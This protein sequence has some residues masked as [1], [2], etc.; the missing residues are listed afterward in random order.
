MKSILFCFLSFLASTPGILANPWPSWRGDLLGSGTTSETKLPLEWGS[1][2]NMRWRVELPER[3]NSTPV[4]HGDRVFVTQAVTEGNWRGLMC[5]SRKDGSLLWKSGLSYGKKE[6]THRA[7]PYC[8]ASPATDGKI[9]V[10]SYGSAGVA[11]YEV[12]GKQLWHRD[13]GAID[14]VWGNSTSPV[15]YRDLVIHYHGPASNG[16][17]YALDRRTGETRWKW[18]EPAWKTG[19]RTDGFRGRDDEGIIGSFSTPILVPS[20]DGHE[21]VMSFPMELKGFDP[22]TGK[23]LWTCGGLNPLVYT[24]PVYGDGILVAMGG[25]HG[26]SIGVRLGGEGDVTGSHRLWQEVRHNGGIGTGVVVDGHHYYHN[27]N[28]IVFCDE[29][30]TGKTVWKERLPG[31][32]KSWGSLVLSG[33]RIYTLS[34]AGDTVV[35]KASTK[36]LEVLGRS[37]VDEETNSSLA[38]SDG[39]VFLRTHKALWCFAAQ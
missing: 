31:A 21:L 19:K 28:G 1:G 34:Q 3:G 11:A 18:E 32:G 8:S 9:V 2:K 39:D 24:S 14:H 15:L 13:L 33:D 17:L 38:V 27:S 10:V 36:G 22:A 25:Y 7:N 4:V 35:F 12:S 30:R 23:E 26:N 5:F 6:R 20:G 16:V 29:M 37:E